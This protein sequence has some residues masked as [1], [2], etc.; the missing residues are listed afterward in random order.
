M[1]SDGA[2]PGAAPGVTFAGTGNQ[3]SVSLGSGGVSSA[4][5]SGRILMLR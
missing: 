4:F 3:T 2:A 5:V 1:A